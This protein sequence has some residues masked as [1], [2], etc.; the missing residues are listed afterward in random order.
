VRKSDFDPIKMT[1]KQ[2]EVVI[3]TTFHKNQHTTRLVVGQNQPQSWHNSL[4]GSKKFFD[5]YIITNKLPE[6]L[7]VGQN[8]YP[9][10]SK[11]DRPRIR[12]AENLKTIVK[13]A[14]IRAK[15]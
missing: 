9:K 7:V 12:P 3:L 4:L 1:V 14:Q 6:Q 13:K 11:E 5:T 15:F 8:K 10:S 2:N